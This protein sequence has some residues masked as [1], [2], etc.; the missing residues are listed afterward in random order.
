MASHGYLGEPSYT[1]SPKYPWQ[2]PYCEY[3]LTAV[4]EGGRKSLAGF[5]LDQHSRQS[6]DR[7]AAFAQA[8]VHPP[9]YYDVLRL[10]WTDIQFL[11]VRGVK[12]EAD[13]EWTDCKW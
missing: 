3:N 4:T 6:R 1:P 13:M 10:T 2:C 7:M 9:E 11:R 8:P 5:H 12:I